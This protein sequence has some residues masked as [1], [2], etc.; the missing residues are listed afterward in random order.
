MI[1][2]VDEEHGPFCMWVEVAPDLMGQLF[3]EQDRDERLPWAGIQADNGV[4]VQ[5]RFQQLNL[6]H[7]KRSY[8]S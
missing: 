2:R 1:T 7:G 6:K 4:M 3:G 5:S 8:T